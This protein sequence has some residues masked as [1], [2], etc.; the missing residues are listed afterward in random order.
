MIKQLL[1]SLAGAMI[2][3]FWQ[4]FSWGIEN[5]LHS[6]QQTYTDKQEVILEAIAE[7]GLEPGMYALGK[8]ASM[9]E[10]DMKYWDETFNG[11]PWAVLNYQ[12]KFDANMGANLSRGFA[13]NFVISFLLFSM[14][15][16]VHAT[17]IKDALL[18]T[19]GVGL[20]SFM[21]EPYIYHIW[22]GTPGMMAHLIDAVVPWTL[23]GFVWWKMK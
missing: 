15:A 3:F 14:L 1:F 6:D 19:V 20:I 16:R 2:L 22:Y 21:V 9:S 5:N 12:E 18:M 11:K 7:T 8:P 23:I 17:S 10:E 4:F 13:V